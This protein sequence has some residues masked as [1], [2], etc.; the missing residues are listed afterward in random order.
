MHADRTLVT[1]AV[2]HLTFCLAFEVVASLFI[3]RQRCN[4]NIFNYTLLSQLTLYPYA[5]NIY[6][7]YPILVHIHLMY[8][9][10]IALRIKS[11]SLPNLT[12]ILS[13]LY[14]PNYITYTIFVIHRSLSSVFVRLRINSSGFGSIR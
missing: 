11:T 5:I 1:D 4:N 10:I 9:S 14:I 2:V 12:S 3:C 6:I 13:R 7:N 8:S